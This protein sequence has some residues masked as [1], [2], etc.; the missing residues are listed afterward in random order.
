MYFLFL[1]RAAELSG[2]P[3]AQF[4]AEIPALPELLQEEH[5]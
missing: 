5:L 4:G 3:K 1:V 2:A